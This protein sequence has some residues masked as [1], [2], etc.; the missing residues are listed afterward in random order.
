MPCLC[1]M[2]TFGVQVRQLNL[3]EYRLS[4]ESQL[5]GKSLKGNQIREAAG[6]TE[7]TETVVEFGVKWRTFSAIRDLRRMGMNPMPGV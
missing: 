2:L 6:A 7:T 4:V 5:S 3:A 1:S